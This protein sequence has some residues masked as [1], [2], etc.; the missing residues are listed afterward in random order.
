MLTLSELNTLLALSGNKRIVHLEEEIFADDELAD[1]YL[2][3][4]VPG[5][6]LSNNGISNKCYAIYLYAAYTLKFRWTVAEHILLRDPYWATHYAIQVIKGRW[7]E[8]EHCILQ[9]EEKNNI[10]RS[11]YL[12]NCYNTGNVNDLF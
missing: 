9:E 6:Q 4:L 8:A 3:A 10:L 1:S 5:M 2:S 7:P 12:K 11:L